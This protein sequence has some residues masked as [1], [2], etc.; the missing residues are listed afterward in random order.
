MTHVVIVGGGFAGVACA[1]KL[2]SN[3]DV[4][5]T[6]I[7][8]NDYHQF[9]PLLY[10]VATSMLAARDIAYPLRKIAAEFQDFDSKRAE[11]VA[12]D[13][14]AKTVT[15]RH[16]ETYAG[17]YLV[18]A[19][20][21]QPNF[22][23]TPGAEHAFPLYSLDD[24]DRLRTRIIQAFE[25][26]DTDPHLADEGALDFV[27]VGGGPTGVEV[28]GALSEMIHTTMLHEFPSLAPRA[29]VHLVDHGT[30]L[31]KMFFDK[32]HAY[33]ARVLEKDGV[34][35]RLGVGVKAIGPGH[36]GLSDGSTIKTRCVIWGGGLMAAPVARGSGLPQG[37]GGRIDVN[38]DFTVAGFPG[39]FAIGDVAN[40]P[41]KDGK[42][43]PQLG[44]VALQSGASAAGSILAEIK[45]ETAK[46][47]KYLDKGTMAMIGR[48]AAV[49]QV[50]GVELHGKLAFAAWLGVHAALMTGGSNRIDAFE[51]WARDFFGKDRA[52]EALDRSGT[53]RM[54]WEEDDEIEQAVASGATN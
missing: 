53:P 20:G 16:N 45:G 7:D 11:V 2:A 14:V 17:D 19:A 48:G 40:I 13:P 38:P 8:K 37:R 51:S 10:Q 35:L 44:S 39:V 4:R 22:F 3:K 30:E 21:S 33:A 32:G 23:G 42:A 52:P 26:A 36:V 24:A 12:I 46:P 31:L 54:V 5:V 25:E 43:Y 28:A 41:S 50:K 9:Q 18:L 15:T 47:F 29:K 6:L 34:E 49:A 1:R 27:I